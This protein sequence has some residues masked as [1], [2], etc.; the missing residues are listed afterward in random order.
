VLYAPN[1]GVEAYTRTLEGQL[2]ETVVGDL[3]KQIHVQSEN[4]RR[5]DAALAAQHFLDAAE[6]A[7]A[8]RQ[9]SGLQLNEIQVYLM[10]DTLARTTDP[11]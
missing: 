9:Q 4:L 2:R 1:G 7:E 11:R 6:Q 5:R 8:I 10:M 3:R